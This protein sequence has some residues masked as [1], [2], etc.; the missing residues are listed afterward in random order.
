MFKLT[1]KKSRQRNFSKSR[2]VGCFRPQFE[3]L[4][5][6]LALATVFGLTSDNNLIRFDSAAPANVQSTIAVTGVTAGET[7][8]GIDFRPQNGLLYGLGVNAGADTMS[9]Y[10]I[11]QRT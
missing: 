2:R 7:L 3:P 11:S 8:V 1:S 4:E 9:V 10:L 5:S 6:R